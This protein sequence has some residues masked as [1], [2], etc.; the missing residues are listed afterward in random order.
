M[1]QKKGGRSCF[2]R[3]GAFWDTTTQYTVHGTQCP[4]Q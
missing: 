1:E 3:S 4:P 2:I